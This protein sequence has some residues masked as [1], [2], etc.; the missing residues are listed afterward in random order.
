MRQFSIR[1]TQDQLSKLASVLTKSETGDS[2]SPCGR[3]LGR[4]VYSNQAVTTK[5]HGN[6]PSDGTTSHSTKPASRRIA[7]DPHPLSKGRR[8]ANNLARFQSWQYSL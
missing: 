7:G 6:S 5:L 4:G 3:G 2:L 1:E 8:F